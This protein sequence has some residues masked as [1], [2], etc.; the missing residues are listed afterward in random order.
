MNLIILILLFHSLAPAQA[1]PSAEATALYDFLLGEPVRWAEPEDLAL[2]IG[3][4][5]PKRQAEVARELGRMVPAQLNMRMKIATIA[6]ANGFTDQFGRYGREFADD[7]LRIGRLLGGDEFLR[8]LEAQNQAVA[9]LGLPS[10][11]WV[12]RADNRDYRLAWDLKVEQLLRQE[13]EIKK[14]TLAGPRFERWRSDWR[15]KFGRVTNELV[16][17]SLGEAILKG[18]HDRPDSKPVLVTRDG[19]LSGT[20]L[21]LD[22]LY[23]GELVRLTDWPRRT[24]DPDE[25]EASWGLRRPSG[26]ILAIYTPWEIP[27]DLEPEH[28]DAVGAVTL[29]KIQGFA[30]R[31]VRSDQ[32]S[33]I[34]QLSDL[35]ETLPARLT[36]LEFNAFIAD[37]LRR[38]REGRPT[39]REVTEQINETA[40]LDEDEKDL[41]QLIATLRRTGALR[42]EREV[43]WDHRDQRARAAG[44]PRFSLEGLVSE[45]G[46]PE[47]ASG[48]GEPAQLNPNREI[49][50][51]R[52][53]FEVRGSVEDDAFH[54][55]QMTQADIAAWSA[56]APTGRAAQFQLRPIEAEAVGDGFV[57]I[58]T[59]LHQKLTAL[60]VFET[61]GRLLV[62]GRD[63]TLMRHRITG[64]YGLRLK[65]ASITA[66][67]TWARFASESTALPDLPLRTGAAARLERYLHQGG[68]E[69]L[70]AAL[71]GN[72]S[73]TARE[74]NRLVQQHTLYS[75]SQAFNDAKSTG[76]LAEFS[77][78]LDDQGRYCVQCGQ[79]AYLLRA[80]LDQSLP[81]GY[82]AVV[83]S[84]LL[85][86][87]T[88]VARPTHAVVD[89]YRGQKLIMRLN[90]V[91]PRRDPRAPTAE[92]ARAQQR[93]VRDH[94][95]AYD[96]ERQLTVMSRKFGDL[97][98]LPNA[99]PV[100]RMYALASEVRGA[101][102]RGDYDREV[103]AKR[104]HAS[105]AEILGE[106]PRWIT[107]VVRPGPRERRITSTHVRAEA[108]L[109]AMARTLSDLLRGE[110]EGCEE[111]LVRSGKS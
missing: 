65:N 89:I 36:L 24:K 26:E 16:R 15:T 57:E 23:A 38:I 97:S 42:T 37:R 47:L 35:I 88:S 108:D 81:P 75:F 29:R 9:E 109:R 5:S 13:R 106:L 2:E 31:L 40:N 10:V 91:P 21:T 20:P 111:N 59:A 74:L 110:D 39:S 19:P 73:L 1:T 56:V 54:L 45:A 60:E 53:V 92:V 3:R 76:P 46:E 34:E 80:L 94:A 69:K 90:P 49:F 86:A 41:R 82:R 84:V 7:A 8:L 71:G 95:G 72:G 63:Y 58:P 30:D 52:T 18:I 61:D 27:F 32:F 48:D 78:F 100:R 98:R 68:E 85:R 51:T 11:A 103:L 102:K 22:D 6:L 44:W 25:T 83:E 99:A 79:A 62:A 43:Q 87:G 104:V 64:S 17:V 28:F 14:A 96:L 70:A 67:N 50:Q 107:G 66:V 55:H 33:E 101:L 77:R 4:M 93:R 12:L 105:S